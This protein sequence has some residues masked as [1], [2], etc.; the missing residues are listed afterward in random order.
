MSAPLSG[1]LLALLLLGQAPPSPSSP[2]A[3]PPNIVFILAD[4]LGW[5]DLGCFGSGFYK[6]PNIDRLAAQG[7]KFTD[8]YTCG[9]NCQPTRASIISGQ[10][11]PRTG[12][13][14][15]GSTRRFDTHKRPLVPVQN[16]TQ[17][18][19]AI[20]TVAESLKSAGYST[21]MFGK[22]HL[23]SDPQHHPSAQ[24]FDEAIVSMGRHFNFKTN[25]RVE[26]NPNA[27]LAD[28]LT[29]RAVDFL[30]RHQ[31]DRFFLYLP[32]F[33]VHSPFQAKKDLIARFQD[34][35]A[36]GGHHDPRY[37]AMIT[38]LDESVGR[39]LQTLE[40]LGLSDNTFV[41][42]SSDN[43][44]VGGYHAALKLPH[45]GITD[46]APLRGGKGMLYEGGIRVPFIARWPG[47]IPAN[48]TCH[49]PVITIDLYPTF[50]DL[51]HASPPQNQPLDGV[52][53][54]PC[55]LASGPTCS[56]PRNALYWHFPGYLGQ[57][58]NAWRTTPAGAIR[59]GDY[60]L[61]EFFEDGRTELY[62]LRD[63]LSEQHDLAS[64]QP[65]KARALHHQ[66]AS[67]RAS[68]GAP[69]PRPR[70]PSDPPNAEVPQDQ[71]RARPSSE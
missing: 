31:H 16:V 66:L 52:S 20:V 30:E 25:P 61:I 18:D 21:G 49:E 46:N 42:F 26:T 15:V 13:Y 41:L 56:L 32:H 9:P 1:T 11:G 48:S 24:G 28:F 71:A 60:K 2:P 58:K 63:D 45:N 8:A 47:H 59:Q 51:A 54:L 38:S 67:W 3:D 35:P 22:W 50:L 33:A 36:V 29:D 27:Y 14:T 44:G 40:K 53:L 19:P 23:G 5:T 64:Q 62:N 37:A 57:G 12:I 55:L 7:R 69:M 34:K 4:D 17:L 10:Y 70:T 6:T 39:V 43:G 65:E 68:I